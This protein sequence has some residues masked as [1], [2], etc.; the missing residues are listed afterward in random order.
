[1]F[2]YATH[3][4]VIFLGKFIFLKIFKGV[5]ENLTNKITS[6]LCKFFVNGGCWLLFGFFRCFTG[7]TCVSLAT[8]SH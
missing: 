5:W 6:H 1:M 4:V 8:R 3:S 7:V 2:V